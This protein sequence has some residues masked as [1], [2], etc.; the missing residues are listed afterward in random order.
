M[1]TR[2]GVP[3]IDSKISSTV[4]EKREAIG[5]RSIR[6][7]PTTYIPKGIGRVAYPSTR[8]GK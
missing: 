2:E 1:T 8:S 3:F 4:S 6:V 7:E 5:R